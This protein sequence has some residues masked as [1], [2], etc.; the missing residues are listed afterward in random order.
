MRI[1]VSLVLIFGSLNVHA[2]EPP[3]AYLIAGKMTTR[4]ATSENGQR[5]EPWNAEFLVALTKTRRLIGVRAHLANSAVAPMEHW[6]YVSDSDES[7]IDFNFDYD[8]TKDFISGT[9]KFSYSAV[10]PPSAYSNPFEFGI[11]RS[12]GEGIVFFQ[13]MYYFGIT[14]DMFVKL[15]ENEEDHLS[16]E[17]GNLSLEYKGGL[18]TSVKTIQSRTDRAVYG[19]DGTLEESKSTAHSNGMNSRTMEVNFSPNLPNNFLAPWSANIASISEGIDGKTLRNETDI[20]VSYSTI[21]RNAIDGFIDQIVKSVPRGASVLSND[22]VKK[23]VVDGSPVTAIDFNALE[24]AK[25]AKFKNGSNIVPL[26]LGGLA[27][28]GVLGWLGWRKYGR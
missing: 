6:E 23:V 15:L 3:S 10:K 20:S 22:P 12:G 5:P 28:I 17:T 4:L 11:P 26:S 25:R 27:L 24:E 9:R 2:F 19:K 16:L 21:D 13:S 14:R 7:I 1:L 18:L 8:P